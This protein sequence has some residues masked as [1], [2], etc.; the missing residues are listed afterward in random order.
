MTL[1]AKT[2]YRPTYG[3]EI[4][5][6]RRIAPRSYPIFQG[7]RLPV[8]WGY[9]FS[10][11]AFIGNPRIRHAIMTNIPLNLDTAVFEKEDE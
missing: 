8:V 11:L 5:N 7:H 2:S 4:I 3:I 1:N 6:F 9:L 10:A